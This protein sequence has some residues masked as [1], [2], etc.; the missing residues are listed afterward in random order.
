MET[1]STAKEA[2]DLD[3]QEVAARRQHSSPP[4]AGCNVS[5]SRQG[6]QMSR[7]QQGRIGCPPPDE[8]DSFFGDSSLPDSS[9]SADNIVPDL[10][11]SFVQIRRVFFPLLPRPNNGRSGAGQLKGTNDLDI[12]ASVSKPFGSQAPLLSAHP[13]RAQ[14]SPDMSEKDAILRGLLDMKSRLRLLGP[15]WKPWES[16]HLMHPAHRP[17]LQVLKPTLVLSPE[18]TDSKVTGKPCIELSL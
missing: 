9:G 18:W 2:V 8:C 15:V 10:S 16:L 5:A 14:A 11:A 1:L 13:Q 3:G 17:W 7:L 6:M 12:N 4:L